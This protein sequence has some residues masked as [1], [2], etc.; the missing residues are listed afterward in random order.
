MSRVFL[1]FIIA[2]ALS[3]C[4]GKVYW[5]PGTLET[6]GVS[7]QCAKLPDFSQ[8]TQLRGEVN[9]L[10]S[11]SLSEEDP[12]HLEVIAS[13]I[14]EKVKL[15]NSMLAKEYTE[16][17]YPVVYRFRVRDE[18]MP[19]RSRLSFHD[20]SIFGYRLLGEGIHVENKR[21]YQ[22]IVLPRQATLLEICALTGTVQGLYGVGGPNENPDFY[23]RLFV[24]NRE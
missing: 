18:Y 14:S 2:I 20:F 21:V 7:N 15:L 13:K 5:L 23:F 8:F 22:D 24:N 3:G 19:P 12:E 1:V 16:D 9:R 17:L 4:R 10:V 6:G 11:L